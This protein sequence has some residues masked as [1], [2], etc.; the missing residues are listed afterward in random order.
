MIWRSTGW[1]LVGI[2]KRQSS[3][4]KMCPSRRSTGRSCPS[5]IWS[6]RSA[7]VA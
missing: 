5:I 4:R 1:G 3:D 2:E 6:C 7:G